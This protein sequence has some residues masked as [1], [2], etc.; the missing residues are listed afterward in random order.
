MNQK[1]FLGAA[2]EQIFLLFQHEEEIKTLQKKFNFPDVSNSREFQ[3]DYTL[4]ENEWFYLK[5]N[6]ADEECMIQNYIVDSTN[7]NYIR[8]EDFKNLKVL[9]LI[10]KNDNFTKIIF[11]RLYPK[12]YIKSKSLISLGDDGV[13]IKL[14]NNSI[15]FNHSV[16][17]YWCGKEKRVYFKDFTKVKPI[18]KGIEKFYRVASEQEIDNFFQSPFFTTDEQFKKEKIGKKSLRNIA[19]IM[20]DENIDLSDEEAKKKYIE[21]AH[22]FPINISFEE[23]KFKISTN[24]ELANVL[25]VLQENYFESYITKEKR[26]TSGSKK[27]GS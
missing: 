5:L 3:T 6:P 8:K 13:K 19:L 12:L 17:A 23:D 26:E 14:Q 4:D 1:Y 21:Y 11:N 27:I 16:D 2:N 15:E 24:K 9:Y 18:F 22:S 10:E 7:A 20:D 25:N